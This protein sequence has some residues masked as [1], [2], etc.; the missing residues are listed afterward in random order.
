MPPCWF[1]IRI[2]AGLAIWVRLPDQ[3]HIRSSHE[4]TAPGFRV[5][6]AGSREEDE[7]TLRGGF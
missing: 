4:A 6:R 7:T 1:T 5:L 2:R 3:T